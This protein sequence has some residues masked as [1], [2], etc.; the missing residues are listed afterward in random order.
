[1][2]PNVPV[3][4]R[5]RSFYLKFFSTSGKEGGG[6]EALEN[7]KLEKKPEENMQGEGCLVN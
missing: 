5:D 6:V 4:L 2:V 7:R 3:T 1:M